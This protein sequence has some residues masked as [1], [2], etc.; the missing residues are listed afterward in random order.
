MS[1][2]KFGHEHQDKPEDYRISNQDWY[3]LSSSDQRTIIKCMNDQVVR[4]TYVQYQKLL[5]GWDKIQKEHFN[6]LGKKFGELDKK[7]I[8]NYIP[9]VARDMHESIDP[10]NEQIWKTLSNY[11]DRIKEE[12]EAT[13]QDAQYLIKSVVKYIIDNNDCDKVDIV[14]KLS[15]VYKELE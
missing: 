9:D 1:K 12:K 3:N 8:G 10:M 5:D 14:R 7:S 6:V 4:D 13:K 15:E 11:V 2:D